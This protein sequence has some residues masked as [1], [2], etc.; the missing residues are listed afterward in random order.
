MFYTILPSALGSIII[1]TNGRAITGCYFYGQ[2]YFAEI[3]DEWIES[4]THVLLSTAR[5][6]LHEYLHTDRK[7]FNL[8]IDF[9]GTEFQNKVWQELAKIPYGQRQSY[10]DIAKRIG[11]RKA[12]RAVGTAIGKN[13]I[14]VIVPC[15]RVLGT[16]G[17]LAGYAGGLQRKKW[18]LELEQ[19][20]S[21]V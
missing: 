16:N 2:R 10:A 3:P 13:P 6:Q 17:S 8:P 15:H 18:L 21:V 1:S 9:V 11:Q 7:Q 12:V 4:D 5:R 19:T 14:S 20:D